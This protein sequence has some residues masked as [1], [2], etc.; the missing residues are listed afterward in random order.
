MAVFAKGIAN[1]MPLSAYCGSAEIMDAA[2][3]L[4]IIIS[5]TLGGETLSLAAAK[6]ALTFI[7]TNKVTDK[8]WQKGESMWGRANELFAKYDAPLRMKGFW[9]CAAMICESKS[10][11]FK[12]KFMRSAFKNGLCLYIVNYTNY[13][14]TDECIDEAIERL[15]KALKETR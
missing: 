10:P 5:S 8:L 3:K 9:P 2:E 11:G 15:E 4:K 7:K 1:G 12:E 6:A 13:S 14:H